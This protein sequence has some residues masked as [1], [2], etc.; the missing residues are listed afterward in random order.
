MRNGSEGLAR[1]TYLLYRCPVGNFRELREGRNCPID[2]GADF[3]V[4][5]RLS[6]DLYNE[7]RSCRIR[8]AVATNCLRYLQGQNE[9]VGTHGRD[10]YTYVI[11]RV[12]CPQDFGMDGLRS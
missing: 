8:D 9:D 12:E 3:I 2:N 1:V 4:M 11:A 7:E 5:T 10:G 6:A